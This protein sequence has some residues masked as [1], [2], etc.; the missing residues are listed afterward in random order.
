MYCSDTIRGALLLAL[1]LFVCGSRAADNST[2]TLAWDPNPEPNIAGYRLYYGPS[3]GPYT[4]TNQLGP[5]PRTTNPRHRARTRQRCRDRSCHDEARRER[6]TGLWR[7][8]PS[9]PTTH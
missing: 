2:L 6:V 5:T 9:P 1:S 8:R 4:G 3:N 7:H